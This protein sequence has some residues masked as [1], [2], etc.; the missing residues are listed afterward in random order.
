MTTRTEELRELMQSHKITPAMI[1]ELLDR[2]PQT[3]RI[4]LCRS[5]GRNIPKHA[6][7]LLRL[8]LAQQ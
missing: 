2:K 6:L 5:Q 1:G 7:D 3:V 4:W 8:K